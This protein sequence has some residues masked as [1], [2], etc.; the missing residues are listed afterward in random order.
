VNDRATKVALFRYALVREPAD[1]ALSKAVRGRLVRALSEATH[2]GPG[3][4]AVRVS[5]G[6]IDRWI[7]DWR[8]G[9]F[10][11]LKPTGRLV[12]PRSPAAMLSLAVDLRRED[13][14]R[15]AA[16]IAEMIRL[17]QGWSPSPP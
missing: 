9:G 12:E 13:P 4:E 3:G 6:T 14:A 7:R 5:R 15:T 16:H 11:A 10:E 8:R 1:P 17:A 2:A